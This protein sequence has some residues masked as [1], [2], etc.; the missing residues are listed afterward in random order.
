MATFYDN[1]KSGGQCLILKNFTG[2]RTYFAGALILSTSSKQNNVS[3]LRTA[4]SY[5][6]ENNYTKAKTELQK[7]LVLSTTGFY[8]ASAYYYLGVIAQKE[9]SISAAKSNFTKALATV[10]VTPS[11]VSYIQSTGLIK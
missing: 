1:L 3:C 10:G 2:A 4:Q 5:L 7:V 9:K 8:A 11:Q 6:R